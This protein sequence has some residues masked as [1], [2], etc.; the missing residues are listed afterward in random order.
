MRFTVDVVA[1]VMGVERNE[2]TD[3]LDDFLVQTQ[4]NPDGILSENGS[5]EIPVQN[6]TPRTLWLYSFVSDLQWMAMGRYGFATKHRPGNRGSEKMEKSRALANA[7]LKT[8]A[9]EER[10][11]APQL[12]RLLRESGDKD[13]ARTYQRMADYAARREVMREQAFYITTINKDNWEQW[14]CGR[15]AKFLIEAGKTIHHITPHREA[16]A[17]HEEACILARR[18]GNRED[19]AFAHYCCGL[20]WVALREYKLAR[21]RANNSLRISDLISRKNTMVLSLHLLAEIECAEGD[22]AKARELAQ[23]A[24]EIAQRIGTR[25]GTATLLKLLSWT[26]L[27]EGDLPEA[28]KHAQQAL[29]V[30]QKIG[31]RHCAAN[32]VMLLA[33]IAFA[34]GDLPEARKLGQDALLVLEELNDNGLIYTLHLLA[35]IECAEGDL[36]KAREFAQRALEIAQ[37]I[38]DKNG[39]ADSLQRLSHFAR[40]SK[41]LNEAVSLLALSILIFS[42]F[43]KPSKDLFTR[44]E[45]LAT[46]LQYTEEQLEELRLRTLESYQ[47]D[48][49]KEIIQDA[50]TRLREAIG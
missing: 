32:S 47:R 5:V 45:V 13:K 7:L 42:Q 6:G 41:L 8:Y 29:G 20:T 34:E 10:L 26:D 25:H 49:G 36:A 3:F 46:D 50:L 22:L 40:M 24:L 21:E 18:A 15:A 39:I 37:E 17:V 14:L 9:P 30:L 27:M 19:E 33:E 35:E 23:R 38:D 28:R 43:V 4:D 2:L 16:L 1:L 12:A 31:D 11:V 48:G 44:L